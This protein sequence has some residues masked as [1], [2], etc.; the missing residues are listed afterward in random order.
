MLFGRAIPSIY[1]VG[2]QGIRHNICY[3]RD[4]VGQ[5]DMVFQNMKEV[6][7]NAGASMQ[8]VV[9]LN[10]YCRNILDMP[11]ML[12]VLRKYFGEHAPARTIVQVEQLAHPHILIEVDAVAIVGEEEIII[13]GK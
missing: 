2:Q 10:F 4:V 1:Q 13:D 9:K 3:K 11:D 12:P 6:L 5:I 8:D 7:E